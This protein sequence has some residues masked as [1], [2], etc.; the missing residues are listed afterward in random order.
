VDYR[1]MFDNPWLK[2]WDL[3]GKDATLTIERVAAGT[4]EN[5]KDKTKKQLPVVYFKGWSKPLGLNK[6]NAKTV[7][8]LYGTMTETWAGKS[9]TLY[10]SRTTMG[11]EEMDCIRV[12]PRIPTEASN[13]QQPL[14][15]DP[16]GVVQQ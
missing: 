11:D 12:R 2:A 5:P 3:G 13:G 1:S 7:A 15:V 4:I 14:V 9:I 6:T 16:D 10:P 8:A